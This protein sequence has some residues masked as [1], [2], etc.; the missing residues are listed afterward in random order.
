V[1]PSNNVTR[2]SSH[3]SK[4]EGTNTDDANHCNKDSNSQERVC[5]EGSVL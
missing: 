2:N 1:L 3:G 4:D 5:C